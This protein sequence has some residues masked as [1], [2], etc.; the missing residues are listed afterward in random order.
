M[1]VH[2]TSPVAFLLTPLISEMILINVTNDTRKLREL[3]VLSVAAQQVN[4]WHE[5]EVSVR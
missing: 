2:F 4:P 3:E 5:V 1:F